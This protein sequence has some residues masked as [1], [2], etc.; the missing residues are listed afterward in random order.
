MPAEFDAN[1]LDRL[2]KRA[3]L[4]REGKSKPLP[5]RIYLHIIRELDLLEQAWIRARARVVRLEAL[6]LGR[7]QV[8]PEY[9]DW[10]GQDDAPTVELDTM[11]ERKEDGA[12]EDPL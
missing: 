10:G 8:D 1:F 5:D 2:R 3:D 9:D 7:D 11:E 6:I 4:I 12:Q